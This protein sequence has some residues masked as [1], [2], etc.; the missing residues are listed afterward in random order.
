MPYTIL[1]TPT[2]MEDISAA[3]EYYNALAPDLG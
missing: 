1:L 2:A 3:I